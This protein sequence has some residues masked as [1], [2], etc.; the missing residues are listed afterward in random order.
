MELSLSALCL[1]AVLED[2]QS[3]AHVSIPRVSEMLVLFSSSLKGLRSLTPS[4][5]ACPLRRGVQR[6]GFSLPVSP[7]LTGPLCPELVAHGQ[8]SREYG[9]VAA[10]VCPDLLVQEAF[11]ESWLRVVFSWKGFLWGGALVVWAVTSGL[12]VLGIFLF[13]LNLLFLLKFALFFKVVRLL[14]P[15]L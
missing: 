12:A 6:P 8:S 7:V 11:L 3:S 4:Y 14:T 15:C 5:M 9:E 10:H 13:F 2:T 1:E